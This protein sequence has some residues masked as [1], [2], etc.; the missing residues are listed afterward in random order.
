MYLTDRT[1]TLEMQRCPRARLIGYELDGG[2]QPPSIA[3]PLVTGSAVHAG[4][5][6]LLLGTPTNQAVA[7]ALHEFQRELEGRDFSAIPPE[8]QAYAVEEQRALSEALV[9]VY[10]A[11]Q[12]KRLL[13][14]FE[15]VDVE[16][17]I[18]MPLG[19][20]LGW[21]A[22]ADAI[23]RRKA[24]GDLYVYSLKTASEYNARKEEENRL[25]MQ[26][27][28]ELAAVEHL[29][30]ERVMGVKMEFLVK[31]RRNEATAWRQDSGLVRPWRRVG[32]FA[33]E[34]AWQGTY[35]CA[36]PQTCAYHSKRPSANPYHNLSTK[37]GWERV[38]VWEHM[39]VGE[40]IDMLA[41]G[42]VQ[43]EAGDPLD[44]LVI[45]PVPYYRNAEDVLRWKRQTTAQE[46]RVAEGAQRC[47]GEH[48]E[49]LCDAWFPMHRRSCVWPSACVYYDREVSVCRAVG[50]A[51]QDPEGEG[52]VRRR[53]H[54][55]PEA[56]LRG[57]TEGT[58][59]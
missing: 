8:E 30:G 19:P 40:W 12:L 39:P 43:P 49:E 17:E 32:Q 36:D 14:E 42:Q 20:D 27:V 33:T 13:G 59:V 44:R 54:H 38:N 6:A 9:R 26:G 51:L 15:V 7:V 47:R 4:V 2:W 25:D 24:D 41:S 28:S 53:A 21:M 46:Y 5:G 48:I 58:S 29:T 22:R 35:P 57:Q 3:L 18:V 31:G 34:W 56:A 11:C 52:W 10:A 1:R 16:K 45:T 23:L 55:A 50:R 37:E